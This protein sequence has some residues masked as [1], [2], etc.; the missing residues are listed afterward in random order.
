MVDGPALP[1]TLAQLEADAR[2]RWRVMVEDLAAGGR[3]P[4]PH[5]LLE[6]AAV[7]EIQQP[8]EALERAAA[9]A[10]AGAAPVF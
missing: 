4:H 5:A 3:A 2:R 8:G 1:P 9:A 7:L 10:R 6:V